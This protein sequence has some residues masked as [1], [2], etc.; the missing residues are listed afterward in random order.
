MLLS[1]KDSSRRTSQARSRCYCFSE[2]NPAV[3]LS[4]T[5]RKQTDLRPVKT[6]S[7]V[8]PRDNRSNAV[9]PVQANPI[10]DGSDKDLWETAPI[11]DLEA[12]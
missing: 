10:H 8:N 2:Q 3:G 9:I 5:N 11:Q 4:I 1:M 7:P 6:K 12:M